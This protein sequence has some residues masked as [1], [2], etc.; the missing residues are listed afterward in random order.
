MSGKNKNQTEIFLLAQEKPA[1]SVRRGK[2]TKEKEGV[3][4]AFA[5]HVR[6]NYF[7]ARLRGLSGSVHKAKRASLPDTNRAARLGC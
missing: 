3:F 4:V 2:M 7:R 5:S 6:G 1:N